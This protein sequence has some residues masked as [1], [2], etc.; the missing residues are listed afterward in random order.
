[1]TTLTAVILFA[2]IASQ[3]DE[4]ATDLLKY[5]QVAN[6]AN[7]DCFVH[8]RVEFRVFR[9]ENA[10]TGDLLTR[11]TDG[12]HEARGLLL[13]SA[14]NALLSIEYN[15]DELV[16]GTKLLGEKQQTM[17]L[18][19]QT[20]LTDGKSTLHDCPVFDPKRRLIVNSVEVYP[21]DG[22]DFFRSFAKFLYPVGAAR[23]VTNRL[24]DDIRDVLNGDV[25]LKG[26]VSVERG[27]GARRMAKFAVLKKH[28]VVRHYVIDLDSGAIPLAIT[29]VGRDGTTMTELLWGELKRVGDAAWFPFSFRVNIPTARVSEIHQVTSVDFAKSPADAE[30]VVRFRGPT[31]FTDRVSSTFQKDYTEYSL[32]QRTKSPPKNRINVQLR[33]MSLPS[34]GDGMAGEIEAPS[35]LRYGVLATILTL[36]GLLVVRVIAKRSS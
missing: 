26:D 21:D 16:A 7:V 18:T 35:Y 19:S 27:A 23:F 22:Y 3:P 4:R 15:D 33:G 17:A 30:F 28:G 8:G 32:L 20:L 36:I 12:M 29:D 10:G 2:S 14:G 11:K 24:A 9:G 13:F 1:M 31:S 5:I 6:Q 25:S 34:S